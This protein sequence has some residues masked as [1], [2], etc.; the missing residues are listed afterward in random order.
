MNQ[1]KNNKPQRPSTPSKIPQR[2]SSKEV[3]K[4]PPRLLKPTS[5]EASQ[6]IDSP[7]AV[8]DLNGRKMKPETGVQAAAAVAST[9]VSEGNDSETNEEATETTS[10][11][12][13]EIAPAPSE[14]TVLSEMFKQQVLQSILDPDGGILQSMLEGSKCSIGDGGFSS[15]SNFDVSRSHAVFNC[16]YDGGRPSSPVCRHRK[17]SLRLVNSRCSFVNIC[18]EECPPGRRVERRRGFPWL[19]LWVG[20]SFLLTMLLMGIV[21]LLNV[22]QLTAIWNGEE[23]V[24]RVPTL[25]SLEEESFF[26][27]MTDILMKLWMSL[28]GFIGSSDGSNE[29]I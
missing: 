6:V 23:W 2:K 17:G 9:I 1:K 4:L 25:P 8:F 29:D 27:R 11:P 19:E 14:M 13:E 7:A 28:K 24:R 21:L 10:S 12:S 20:L 18:Q 5:S 15:D 26:G 3:L 16:S 22:E